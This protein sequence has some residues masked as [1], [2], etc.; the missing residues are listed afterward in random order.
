QPAQFAPPQTPAEIAVAKIWCEILGVQQVGLHDNFFDLGG[1]SLMATQLIS[2]LETFHGVQP[3]LRDIFDS[4]TVAAMS[5]WLEKKNNRQETP[6]P[7]TP[8]STNGD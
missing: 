7:L 1:H 4:P 2:R 6:E 8:V 5:E 3:R